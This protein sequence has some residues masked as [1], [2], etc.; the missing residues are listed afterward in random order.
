MH[1]SQVVS[2]GNKGDNRGVPVLEDDA[3]DPIICFVEWLSLSGTIAAA[4]LPGIVS[5]VKAAHLFWHGCPSLRSHGCYSFLP[6]EPRAHTSV[7]SGLCK[8]STAEK[9]PPK[10][11]VLHAHLQRLFDRFDGLIRTGGLMHG[12]AC[13][14]E[15]VFVLLWQA[16]LRP[17]EILGTKRNPTY[18][19]WEWVEFLDK[20]RKPVH[21][22][23]PFDQI[24]CA[25][26]TLRRAQKRHGQ[27]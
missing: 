18:A 22:S 9:K 4:Q 26:L 12:E 3:E 2:A 11:P 7:L 17:D 21:Y 8:T 19:V 10:E 16:I 20:N 27:V 23:T 25:E 1:P 15:L 6:P 14:I 5:A 24:G 13:A